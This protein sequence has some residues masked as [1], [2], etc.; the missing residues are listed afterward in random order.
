MCRHKNALLKGMRCS[1]M[2]GFASLLNSLRS[3]CC[4]LMNLRQMNVLRIGNMGGPQLASLLIFINLL[5]VQNDG[6]SF[7]STLLMV[8]SHGRSCKLGLTSNRSMFRAK[9][10]SPVLQ[11]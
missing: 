9:S 10:S 5:N 8:F 3:N 7:L 2:L 11:P 4:F 6:Q 1:E